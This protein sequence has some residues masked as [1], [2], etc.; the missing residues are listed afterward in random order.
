MAKIKDIQAVYEGG[1]VRLYVPAKVRGEEKVFEVLLDTAD[2]EHIKTVKT[3]I[4]ISRAAST[5]RYAMFGDDV[6]LHRFIVGATE[7]KQHVDHI[8]H[9][10]LDN[11]RE[12]LRIVDHATNLQNRKGAAVNNKT[13]VRNVRKVRERYRFELEVFGKYYSKYFGTLEEAAAYA[14]AKRKEL[15]LIG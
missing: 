12:N 5:H 6:Q 3:A 13:G 8:N 9:D 1:F 7:R 15:G 11:R 4:R 10:T 2:W 14:E